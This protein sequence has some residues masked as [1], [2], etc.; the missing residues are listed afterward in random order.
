MSSEIIPVSCD[1]EPTEERKF[2][3][4]ETEVKHP[5]IRASGT[6]DTLPENGCKH[7]WLDLQGNWHNFKSYG[8]LGM[9]VED[10]GM[11]VYCPKCGVKL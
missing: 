3:D 8:F 2:S 6:S 10:S 7:G 11:C 1:T 9:T 4:L 5:E